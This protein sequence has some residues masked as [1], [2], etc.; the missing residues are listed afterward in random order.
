L[1][2]EK[3]IN[4][5]SGHGLKVM[6]FKVKKWEMTLQ[7]PPHNCDGIAYFPRENH[8]KQAQMKGKE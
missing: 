8:I 5:S 7:H 3:T 6:N 1:F 4:I 2:T